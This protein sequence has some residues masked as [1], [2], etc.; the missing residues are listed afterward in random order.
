M[1]DIITFD[2][3]GTLVDWEGGIT[4]AMIGAARERGVELKSA[5]V[6]AAYHDVEPELQRSEYRSY[7]EVLG[8]AACAVARRLN[9]ELAADAAGFL[10]ESLVDWN[11]FPDTGPALRALKS[12]G[13]QLGILSNIDNDL[14]AGTL[15]HLPVA[16]D[17]IV[18]AQDVRSYKPAHAHFI[19]ARELMDDRRWLHAAQSY[20]HDVEP[21][22]ELG[23][24]TV[25]IN[26]K[27]ERLS[28]DARPD[29]N[30]ESL[31][32]LVEW[33]KPARS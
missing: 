13:F 33:L 21:A 24:P 32:G 11:P 27:G 12:A 6:L 1:Y 17:L 23:I 19:R 28:G 26:R 3:Y 25:W 20:F 8:D 2:C 22:C 15:R 7:R 18:T 30:V 5:E 16:F 4:Q 31:D 29:G 14:L 10:A 9:W